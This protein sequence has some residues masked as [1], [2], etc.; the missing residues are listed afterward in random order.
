[1]RSPSTVASLLLSC[2]A[3]AGLS[4]CAASTASP[5]AGDDG[6]PGV[7]AEELSSRT[8]VPYVLQFVGTYENAAAP[9]GSVKSLTLTRTGRYTA[10][11]AGKTKAER[12]A[13]F[14]VAH[15]S[16]KLADNTLRMVTTGLAWTA[17]IDG[18][19]GKLQLARSGNTTTVT[20]HGVV[21]PNE[22]VCDA[23]GGSWTD[24]DA[25]AATGLYCV[26]G[27]GKS[28]IPSSGGCIH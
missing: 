28:Y 20:A 11:I 10:T 18:Y 23:S 25:D 2:L 6:D 4:G 17:T 12:G 14:G 22:S 24:D 26:C 1:M 9:T 7:T 19:T 15:F 27:A 13:F 8:P 21:G 3:L 5:S 16:G